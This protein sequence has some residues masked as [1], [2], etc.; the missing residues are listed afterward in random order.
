MSI[1]NLGRGTPAAPAPFWQP[2]GVGWDKVPFVPY[3]SFMEY[4]SL[5]NVVFY[6]YSIMVRQGLE[7]GNMQLWSVARY[8]LSRGVKQHWI[9]HGKDIISKLTKGVG[10]EWCEFVNLFLVNSLDT[11][12][13]VF[14]FCRVPFPV[15]GFGNFHESVQDIFEILE[16][17]LS[18]FLHNW[19]IGPMGSYSFY[20]VN[21]KYYR[22]ISNDAGDSEDS[23]Q[24]YIPIGKFQDIMAAFAMGGHARLGASDNCIVGTLNDEIFRCIFSH[25]VF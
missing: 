24:Y 9:T 16:R 3:E 7:L 20:L 22:S 25:G 18:L 17:E 13:R 19:E 23:D 14:V 8:G 21:F 12:A 10:S 2:P 5:L 1:F 15:T 4:R 11:T 6:E